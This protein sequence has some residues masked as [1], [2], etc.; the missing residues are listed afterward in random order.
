MHACINRLHGH[1]TALNAQMLVHEGHGINL[2]MGHSKAHSAVQP[3]AS[4]HT[5]HEHYEDIGDA[6]SA[7]MRHVL[8]ELAALPG[9]PESSFPNNVE[10]AISGMFR[11]LRTGQSHLYRDVA[12]HTQMASHLQA[13]AQACIERMSPE[14]AQFIG[15]HL[16]IEDDFERIGR[17][18][19]KLLC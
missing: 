9:L 5:L 17:T 11:G 13:L 15:I 3:L 19:G 10:V 6:V 18:G 14:D 1:N 7:M 4:F 12:K 8:G 16:R 2:L